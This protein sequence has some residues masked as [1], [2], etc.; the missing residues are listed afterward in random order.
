[1]RKDSLTH[2]PQLSSEELILEQQAIIDNQKNE[3][4]YLQSIMRMLPG[5]VYWKNRDGVYLGCNEFVLEMAGTKQV[6]GKTDFE[7]PW[8]EYAHEIAKIDQTVMETD[9]TIEIEEHPT[10]ANGQQI[11][12]LTRKAPL[13]DESGNTVGVIGISVNITEKK[14]Q[15]EQ[16]AAFLNVVSHEIRGPLNNIQGLAQSLD[17]T[18]QVAESYI[19]Q[20]ISGVISEVKRATSLLSDMVDLFD[21]NFTKDNARYINDV[22]VAKVIDSI[23]P[24]INFKPQTELI[25]EISP[26]VPHRININIIKL[27]NIL[28]ILLQNSAE[29][30]KQGLIKML[31]NTINIQNKPGL[32]IELFDTSAGIYPENKDYVF[33]A[34][35]VRHQIDK[36]FLY[37]K[38]HIK[39]TMAKCLIESM[40]GSISLLGHPG[41][42]SEFEI[43]IPYQLADVEQTV[44]SDIYTSS[45][46]IR[47]NPVKIPAGLKVLVVEDDKIT[48][49]LLADMFKQLKCELKQVY[50]GQD[51]LIEA[52]QQSY[53]L[54]S[55][56]I[57]LPD[58]NGAQVLKKLSQESTSAVVAITSHA[59]KADVD[60]LYRQGFM[61][62]LTKPVNQED[63]QRLLEAYARILQEDA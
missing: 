18:K 9:T 4:F 60:Y 48:N 33:N 52:Q 22:N 15:E 50:T 41:Q 43:L 10:L 26:N 40:G 8:K 37:H 53:D 17:L 54:I 55:L 16:K 34:L 59:T 29:Q 35:G 14:Q 32:Y 46:F 13:K 2:N 56:D 21:P 39:L 19:K 31:V 42:G 38:P 51:A 62:V 44:P 30:T 28:K 23:T 58:I 24:E 63:I 36:D 3:I 11:I 5:S 47:D 6:I 49:Q 7:L 61:A 12:M 1:M 20:M 57:T 45:A 25:V 27:R